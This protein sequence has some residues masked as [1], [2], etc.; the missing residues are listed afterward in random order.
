MAATPLSCPLAAAPRLRLIAS[1]LSR[2]RARSPATPAPAPARAFSSSLRHKLADPGP[3]WS[4]TTAASFRGKP[5]SPVYTPAGS[6][7]PPAAPPAAKRR[8]AP[9]R[10]RQGLAADHPLAAWRDQ[11]L[12][13]C[14]WGAGHDWFFVEGLPSRREGGEIRGRAEEGG[15]ETVEGTGGVVMGV[16]DGVG[17]WEDSGVDPSHFAQALMWFARERVRTGRALN[18]AG[19][20][21]GQELKELLEGAYEDVLAE[22]GI[23]AGSSTACLVALDAETGKLHAANLGDS[24]FLI[25]RPTRSKPLPT[26]PA[27]PS[28]SASSSSSDAT[29][30]PPVLYKLLHAQ[31]PQIHFFNAPRQLAKLP[32]SSSSE[33]ALVDSPR[34]ADATPPEG[35]QLEEG[36]VVIVA[37]DGFGDNVF[38]EGELEQLV[39]LVRGKADESVAPGGDHA[40]ADQAHLLAASVAQTAVNFAR[41]VSFKEDKVTPFEVEARRWGYRDLKGGK[42]DDVT[43]V[44]AVVARR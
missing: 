25:L 10:L 5:G 9:L 31:P 12:A 18:A 28:S 23:V 20:P 37:T 8:R 30:P 7:G 44:V 16:A 19:G 14:P 17:G 27:S 4:F 42:V 11:Q 6:G 21:S 24:S 35:I 39:A 41:L 34:D 26:P 33:G 43:V 13:A 3:T 32:P 1:H 36:D 15:A 29:T 2:S 40:Q 22:E 38:A